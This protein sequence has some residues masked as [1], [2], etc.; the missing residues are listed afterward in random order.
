MTKRPRTEETLAKNL[1]F[2]MKLRGWSEG[3]AARESGV[4]QKTVNNMLNQVY[5]AKVDTVDQL[6][7]AFGLVGWQ[8]L[9]P[10]LPQDLEAGGSLSSLIQHW[11][12][13]SAEGREAVERLANREATFNK[14]AKAS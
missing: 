14:Q 6:A 11:A 13:S 9:I 4:S 5:R 12:D 8:L 2:L 7:A 10:N 3:D 1:R